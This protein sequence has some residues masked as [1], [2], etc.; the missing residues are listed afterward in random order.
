MVD[1]SAFQRLPEAV[2]DEADRRLRTDIV[3]WL[4]TVDATGTPMSSVVSFFWDG[5]TVVFYSEPDTAK[6]SSLANNPKVWFHLNSDE[7]GDRMVS[8]EGDCVVDDDAPKS[9]KW[10]EYLTKYAEPYR[11]WGMDPDDTAHRFWVAC[12]IS[13]ERVRAW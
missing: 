1:H 2:A 6:L 8:H 11:R 5:E 10:P 12:Q 4:T 9:N 7:I 3:G 13:P